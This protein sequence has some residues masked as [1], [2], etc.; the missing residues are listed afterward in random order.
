MRQIEFRGKTKTG[1]WIY[2]SLVYSKNIEPAIYFEKGNDVVKEM[3]WAYVI[4]ESIGQYTGLKDKNGVKIYEGDIV[5]QEKWISIGKYVKAICI[6]KYKMVS[7]ACECIGDWIGSYAD[8]NG[9]AKVIG[10]IF[11][12]PELL[13]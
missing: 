9:N 4:P 12:N 2:G 11:E 5:S 6:V 7:F 1:N 3:G 10:D 8:L 13:K